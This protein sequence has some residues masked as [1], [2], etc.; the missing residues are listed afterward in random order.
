MTTA[1]T[2]SIV[3][4]TNRPALALPVLVPLALLIAINA[5]AAWAAD[6]P[7]APEPDDTPA[8]KV[9]ATLAPIHQRFA[10]DT[11][12]AKTDDVPDF[13][14]HISPLLGR[15]GCNGRAC[16][17]SFQGQ[18][19]FRLSLFG[20]DLNTDLAELTKKDSDRVHLEK[21]ADSLILQKPTLQQDHEGGER[22]KADS[23]AYRVLHRWIAGGAKAASENGP[24]LERLTISPA[25][26]NFVKHEETV[27][28]T[29]VAHW[30][31]GTQEDVTPLCRFRTNDESVAT[32]DE[33]G[34]VTSRSP[35][36]THIVAFYDNGVTPVQVIRPMSD[37]VGRRYP[38][39]PTPT[40]IDE[41]VVAKLRKLGIVQSELST[42]AEFLRRV[43]LDITGTLPTPAE[44]EAFLADS[45]AGKRTAKIEAL[46]D[47]P[48]YAAWWATKLC[49]IT[50]NNPR[51]AADQQ[52]GEQQSRQW[53]DWIHRRV[54]ENVPY[55][56]IVEGIALAVSRSPGQS[57]EDYCQ[58]MSSYFHTDKPADFSA[59]ETMPYFWSR[60]RE[61]A[62]EGKGDEL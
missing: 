51:R 56:K 50:G 53:Y 38:G 60:G 48:S 39:A 52:L 9:A 4:N 7:R 36:N 29:A 24:R 5:I 58:E 44:V 62:G 18:G 37:L 14:R 20:Y 1:R 26:I 59:R 2:Q 8:A 15:L 40:K 55:D 42:D 57:Y 31:D 61:G 16:H 34:R 30:S 35:G 25:E 43:T 13:Q 54:R 17:G 49:D 27:V 28:L 32:V 47:S 11:D 19:D 21:P 45:S 12:I 41:L 3:R 6:A 22:F 10:A 23:W 46:L 33:D